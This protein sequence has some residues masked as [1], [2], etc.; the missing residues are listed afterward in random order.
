MTP[1]VSGE[2]TLTC[3]ASNAKEAT[4]AID[5]ALESLSFQLLEK[6]EVSELGHQQA[7]VTMT[8]YAQPKGEKQ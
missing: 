6:R 2:L 7:M 4:S 8:F 3:H 1:E 5:S